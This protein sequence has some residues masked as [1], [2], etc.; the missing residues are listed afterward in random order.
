[1]GQVPAEK[2][3]EDL[4]PVFSPFGVIEKLSIVRGPDSKSRGCAM[5]EYKRW[6]DAEQAMATL[7]G[8]N[9]FE[10]GSGRPLVVHFA[11]PRRTVP[12]Q[13]NEQA[14]APRKLFVGQVCKPD[15]RDLKC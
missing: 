11:N 8:N 1:M 13:S 3:E 14:I 2:Q 15:F 9:P 12:G 10:A 5:V 4:F 6:T 7:H